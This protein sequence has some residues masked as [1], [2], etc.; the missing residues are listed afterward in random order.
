MSTYDRE[1]LTW[2]G[3]ISDS[4]CGAKHGMAKMTDRECTEMCVKTGAKYIF[5]SITVAKIEMPK[6]SK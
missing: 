5:V 6:G 2:T 4:M 3:T 1:D